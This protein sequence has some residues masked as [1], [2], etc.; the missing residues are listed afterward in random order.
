MSF[1]GEAMGYQ[2]V[3]GGKA[4]GYQA[5]QAAYLL[6]FHCWI[7]WF[8]GSP[9][10]KRIPWIQRPCWSWRRSP[11]KRRQHLEMG[12]HEYFL[13]LMTVAMC[14]LLCCSENELR[15]ESGSQIIFEGRIG[16]FGIL[17]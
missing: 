5:W 16:L 6:I 12:S 2:A 14:R 3:F 9:R 11:W 1:G 17:N 13:D 7:D 15:K 8:G 4:M 10:R